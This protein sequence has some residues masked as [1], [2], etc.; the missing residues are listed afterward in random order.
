MP[1]RG[2]VRS[3][4][5]AGEEHRLTGTCPVVAASDP[6]SLL[7]R[8]IARR[9]HAPSWRRPIRDRCWRGASLDGDM[10]RRGGVR[11]GI[12][13]GEEHRLT[14]T[15]P[16]VAASDPGSLLARSI[17]RRG[18]APSW[19]RPIRDRY[20]RG[21]TLNGDM[22]RRGGVRSGIVAG[23]EHR[24]TGTCPVVAWSL[25]KRLWR[26]GATLDAE[27][28][29]ITPKTTCRQREHPTTKKPRTRTRTKNREPT[30]KN[31][32]PRTKNQHP[33]TTP[34]LAFQKRGEKRTRTAKI[35]RRPI[36][37]RITKSSLDTSERAA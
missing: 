4:I 34:Y 23:E 29:T 21:A 37:I 24:L 28:N 10:P 6:G 14:G 11:S 3:G 8:S 9:G 19:R 2:G 1:R 5:V 30:P 35:S 20:W 16:V 31:Q 33:R 36:I 17:A 12:V 25:R 22:P 27:T 15:C 18:H 7:A 13:A 32:E 26:R